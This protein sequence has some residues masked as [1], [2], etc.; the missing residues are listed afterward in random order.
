MNYN[1]KSC[2]S[3]LSLLNNFFPPW[4]KTVLLNG[5]LKSRSDPQ[6]TQMTQML[7]NGMVVLNR[8]LKARSDPQ[9]TQMTQMLKTEWLCSTGL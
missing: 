6:M 5:T 2:P 7:K 4:L 8:T 1:K 3:C 9:M